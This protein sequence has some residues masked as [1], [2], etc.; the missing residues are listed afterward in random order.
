MRVHV[1]MYVYTVAV[2]IKFTQHNHNTYM[3]VLCATA[4]QYLRHRWYAFYKDAV[5][6]H[7]VVSGLRSVHNMDRYRTQEA[8]LL[9]VKWFLY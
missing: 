9:C 5:L 2:K 4:T 8:V 1:Q 7:N 6:L 3:Y